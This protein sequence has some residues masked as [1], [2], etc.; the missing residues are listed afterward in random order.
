[1][2]VTEAKGQQVTLIGVEREVAQGVLTGLTGR[3]KEVPSRWSIAPPATRT[4][5][6]GI[7]FRWGS[8]GTLPGYGWSKMPDGRLWE[9]GGDSKRPV[10]GGQNQ[11]NSSRPLGVPDGR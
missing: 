11:V 6:A 8:A 9:Q 10:R 2:S 4:S 3:I 5:H 7:V 1:V